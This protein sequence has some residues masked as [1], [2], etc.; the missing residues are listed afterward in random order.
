MGVEMIENRPVVNTCPYFDCNGKIETLYQ[1]FGYCEECR[2]PV[3]L[4]KNCNTFNRSFARFC[5]ECGKGV[6]FPETS[7]DSL[8]FNCEK[9]EKISRKISLEESFIE[10]PKIFKGLLW[11]LSNSGTVYAVSPYAESPFSISTLGIEFSNSPFLITELTTNGTVGVPHLISI[12][13]HSIKG[14][15]LLTMS[16][17]EFLSLPSS[18]PEEI[19]CDR[20]KTFCSIV[21]E[22]N[23]LYF[24]KR[25]I[26]NENIAICQLDLADNNLTSFELNETEVAGPIKVSNYIIA[27][28]K[29]K[30][31]LLSEKGDVNSYNFRP[32]F[33]PCLSNNDFQELYPAPGNPPYSAS[34]DSFY[35]QGLF[36]N[37]PHFLYIDFRSLTIS[38]VFIP[39]PFGVYGLSP[40][41]NPVVVSEKDG[42]IAELKASALVDIHRDDQITGQNPPFYTSPLAVAFAQSTAGAKT[43]KFFRKP[44]DMVSEF[45]I[46]GLNDFRT[47]MA[48][49]LLSGTIALV[50]IRES[51]NAGVAIWDL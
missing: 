46:G 35:L 44:D 20:T 29:N 1:T 31:F 16:S 26:Q 47:A 5:R 48:F 14:L 50:Y 27:Y 21:E 3:F 49:F 24:L 12:S 40:S 28:S 41:G 34:G 15:N 36:H 38:Q 2:Y 32:G 39:I 4:C 18:S 17:E 11:F 23:K 6:S 30:I 37:K 13:P 51:K 10:T 19:I 22:N 9:F 8:Q 25:G 43:I 42:R 33:T 7:L 45:Y